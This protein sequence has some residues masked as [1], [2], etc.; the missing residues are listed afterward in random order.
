MSIKEQQR[1]KVVALLAEHLLQTG[2]TQTSLRQLANA[3][4][5]SDRM[6][7]YYFPDK[8]AV[9]AAA[10][11]QVAGSLAAALAELLPEDATLPPSALLSRIA[12]MTTREDMRPVFRVWVE[13]VAAARRE[14]PYTTLAASIIAGFRDWV[15]ARLDLSANADRNATAMAIIAFVDGL[16]L[17]E[18]CSG[19]GAAADA[20]NALDILLQH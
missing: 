18:I 3:A 6:L 16:A 10:I 11:E 14:E 8:A 20:A 17:V 9:M 4:G 5:V 12:T 2:L 1:E 19:T 7:L 13:I 15:A